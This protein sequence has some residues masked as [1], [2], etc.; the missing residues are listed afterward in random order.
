MNKLLKPS[1][2]LAIEALRVSP[3][4]KMFGCA[5]IEAVASAVVQHM[6]ANGNHWFVPVCPRTV[7]H[8]R[9]SDYLIEHSHS[10]G[11]ECS[12]FDEYVRRDQCVNDHFIDRVSRNGDGQEF[13][14]EVLEKLLPELQSR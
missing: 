1:Q 14:R 13:R 10:S 6:A 8:L 11:L 4:A 7:S 5:E 3:F 9:H 2:V 12:F